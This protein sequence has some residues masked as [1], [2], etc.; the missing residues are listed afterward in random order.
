MM[1]WERGVDSLL[2]LMARSDWLSWRR[3]RGVSLAERR[4]HE[5]TVLF[6]S[7]TTVSL[8]AATTGTGAEF[9]AA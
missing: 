7:I 4:G 3:D 6:G 2:C 5:A 8:M 9:N 1:E